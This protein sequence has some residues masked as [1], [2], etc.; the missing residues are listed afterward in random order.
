MKQLLFTALLAMQS[1][2]NADAQKFDNVTWTTELKQ[3]GCDAE[4]IFTATIADGWYIYSQNQPNDNA[5]I[6]PMITVRFL[7][8]SPL[9]KAMV[10]SAM[11]K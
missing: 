3:N 10:I 8:H 4:L 5:K 7:L 11:V 9:R 6:N 2:F 1:L